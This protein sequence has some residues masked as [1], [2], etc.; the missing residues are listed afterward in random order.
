ML[1]GSNGSDVR[2]N[3]LFTRHG[4]GMSLFCVKQRHWSWLVWYSLIPPTRP[5]GQNGVDE[6]SRDGKEKR[7]TAVDSLLML[8]M[9]LALP[10]PGFSSAKKGTLAGRGYQV[11]ASQPIDSQSWPAQPPKRALP[12]HWLAFQRAAGT[13]P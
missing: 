1:L 2:S 4:M 10:G 5:F 6:K 13:G 11:G 3:E 7:P 9:F 12:C 8:E